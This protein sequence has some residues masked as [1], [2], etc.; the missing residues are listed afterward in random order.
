MYMV[1]VANYV[2]DYSVL[3]SNTCSNYGGCSICPV[4]N[5]CLSNCEYLEYPDATKTTATC[6]ACHANCTDGCVKGEH[7]SLCDDGECETCDNF[8][9]SPT[10]TCSTCYGTGHTSFSGLDCICDDVT[11]IWFSDVHD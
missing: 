9:P 6:I 10:S 7:C 11:K 5:Q 2:P 8:D 3:S 4:T 1:G